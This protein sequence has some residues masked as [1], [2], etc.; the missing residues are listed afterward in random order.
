MALDLTL[1][2]TRAECDEVLQDL[3]A[4]LDTYQT[5]DSN[6][7]YTDRQVVRSKAETA[8]L[9]TGV[10]AEIGMYTTMLATP[11]LSARLLKQNQ[12][13]LRRAIDRRD[14]LKDQGGAR[15]GSA[16]ILA[17]ID[18]A[19]IDAQVAVLTDAQTQVTTHRA[20]LAA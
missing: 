3:E 2:T 14:N 9:L 5:R 16:R 8:V 10:E 18:A 12:S 6:L 20:T 1:L 17:A 13:K 19:Q 15:S 4:E 7:G 11:G